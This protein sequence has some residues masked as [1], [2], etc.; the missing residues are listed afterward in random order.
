MLAAVSSSSLNV[1]SIPTN[2]SVILGQLTEDTVT[3]RNGPFY[4]INHDF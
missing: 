2:S 4:N 1:R 3:K